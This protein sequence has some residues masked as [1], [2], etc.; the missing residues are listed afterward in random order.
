MFTVTVVLL[1]RID[2]HVHCFISSTGVRIDWHVHCYSSSTGVRIG[3]HI[4]HC[5]SILNSANGSLQLFVS[6]R[7][8]H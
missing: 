3:C 7:L 4:H 2:R 6:M 1:V 8:Y 5:C